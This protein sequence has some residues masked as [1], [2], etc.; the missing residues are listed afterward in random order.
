MYT[1]GLDATEKPLA[2][3]KAART[4]QQNAAGI[5]GLSIIATNV[6]FDAGSPTL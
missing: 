5:Q 6:G 1:G 4:V 3:G 2:D